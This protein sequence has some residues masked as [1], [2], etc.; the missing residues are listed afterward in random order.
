[1]LKVSG[2]SSIAK[3]HKYNGKTLKGKFE[4]TNLSDSNDQI[5]WAL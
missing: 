3:T 1:M 5:Y 4:R 2:Q